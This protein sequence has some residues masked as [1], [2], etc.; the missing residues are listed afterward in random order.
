M[1]VCMYVSLF[2]C[3]GC[4]LPARPKTHNSPN[5]LTV[6]QAESI[7]GVTLRRLELPPFATVGRLVRRAAADAGASLQLQA[8]EGEG[9]VRRVG[10]VNPGQDFPFCPHRP[11]ARF[12]L[13]EVVAT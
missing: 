3:V 1:C 8:D 4:L 10:R 9:C 12:L 7:A 6:L 2:V 5:W 11:T 13:A